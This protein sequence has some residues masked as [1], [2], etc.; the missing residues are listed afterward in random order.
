[1]CQGPELL[2]RFG[3]EFKQMPRIQALLAKRV[4]KAIDVR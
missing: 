3:P 4:V 2:V 1:M